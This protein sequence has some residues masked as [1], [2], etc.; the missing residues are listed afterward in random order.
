MNKGSHKFSTSKHYQ[1]KNYSKQKSLYKKVNNTKFDR[2]R[3]VDGGTV[4]RKRFKEQQYAELR[5]AKTKK[6]HEESFNRSMVAWGKFVKYF[7]N[8]R[9]EKQV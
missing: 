1:Q 5:N 4:D 9:K 8:I 7:K 2:D 3:F 6:S